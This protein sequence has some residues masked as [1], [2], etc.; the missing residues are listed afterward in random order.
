[1]A[2]PDAEVV[3][4]AQVTPAG[5]LGR[6]A[7]VRGLVPAVAGAGQP[8]D[9]ELEVRL[10][11]LGLPS[12]LHTVRMG[13][14]RA[15]LRL[16]LV[17]RDV[18]GLERERLVEVPLEIRLRLA[19]DAVDQVEREI[20]E[21]GLTQHLERAANVGR[22]GGAAERAQEPRVERLRAE[23]DAVDAGAAEQRRERRV[24]RLGI[25]LDRDRACGGQR[26]QQVLERR[27]LRQRRR[28]AAEVDRL[29]LRCEQRP[30]ERELAEDAPRT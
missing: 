15:G 6:T 11:R 10:H 29:E 12:E 16:E 13:E 26:A 2:A 25:R 1:M 19:G 5:V 18:L 30:F 9:D 14:A 22:L 27:T 4:S 7:E 3:R 28:A 20:V 24:D 17:R 23:R 21:P 8:F